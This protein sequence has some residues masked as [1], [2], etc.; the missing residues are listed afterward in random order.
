MVKQE[1][2]NMGRANAKMSTES[3][4]NPSGNRPKANL[5]TQ[6]PEPESGLKASQTTDRRH[7]KSGKGL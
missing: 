5:S 7:P 6:K 1:T 3:R 4:A 2:K